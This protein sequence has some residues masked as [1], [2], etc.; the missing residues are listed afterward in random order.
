MDWHIV[1]KSWNERHSFFNDVEY[2]DVPD[3][4]FFIMAII[5][6]VILFGFLSYFHHAAP[7]TI[8]QLCGEYY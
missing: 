6:I 2:E 7:N 3:M 4:T 1:M 5:K 8:F